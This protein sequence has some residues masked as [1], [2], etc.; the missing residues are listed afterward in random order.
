MDRVLSGFVRALRSAGA[1]ASTAETIDAARAVALVGYADRDSLKASLGVSLA[2]SQAEKL[3]HDKIFDLYFSPP[4]EAPARSDAAQPPPEP[5]GLGEDGSSGDAGEASE[6]GQPGQSAGGGAPSGQGQ[7]GGAD[8]EADLQALLDLAAQSPDSLAMRM[9][10]ARAAQAA[11]VD[12]IRFAS[13]AAYLTRRM[14]EAL[15]IAPLEAR[16]L[17]RLG[18]TDEASQAEAEALMAARDAL[19][20]QARALVEQRFG[21]FGQSATDNFMNE[22]AVHRPIGRMSPPDIDRMQVAVARMARRLAARHSRRQRIRLR[23]QLDFRRTLRANAGHDGVPVSLHYKHR[24]RDKPRI[25]V[26]CD[27]SGSVAPYV[28][29]LLLFLYALHGE[30][31]DLRTF[32]FSDRLKDVA[33]ALENLPFDQA[34]ELILRDLGSGSTDCGQALVDLQEHHWDAID[35]QTTVL[36]LSDGRNNHGD[37]RLDIFA[38]LA[39]RSKR[40]GWLCPEPPARWGTGD[41]CMLQYRPHCTHVSHCASAVDLERAIDEALAAYG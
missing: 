8:G 9:A 20:R 26:V 38:E 3:L 6:P 40:L 36:V 29:F 41:S 12:D 24:R 27:V 32:A 1:E 16:L 23:G 35:R 18:Q 15:G 17:Q 39:E 13:Q 28:R 22:V 10:M 4:A 25:V 2:K 33:K 21:I 37:P 14:L 30:V 34:M 31:T 19:Q 5:G 7:G 11:G